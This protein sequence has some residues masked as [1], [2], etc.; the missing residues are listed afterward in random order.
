[1]TGLDNFFVE[2]I[3][4]FTHITPARTSTARLGLI[5]SLNQHPTLFGSSMTLP[6][7]HIF[8]DALT[9]GA[10]RWLW[11]LAAVV[12]LAVALFVHAERQSARRLAR[13]VAARLRARLVPTVSPARRRWRF[14][15]ELLAL[16]ALIVA[17][18]RPQLGFEEQTVKRR[19]LD[20]IVAVDVSKSM[21][22]TDLAPNRL[23]R[24]RLALLDLLDVLPGD[25]VGLV[26]F[27][28]SAFLQAPLT[29]D[30]DAVRA[31]TAE[32][33]TDLIPRGGTDI[34]AA[35]DLALEAF[36]QGESGH[37]A[38]VLL[39]DGEELEEDALKSA[40][41]AAAAGVPIFTV[42]LGTTEGSVIP[43]PSDRRQLG[44]TDFVRDAEGKV[45]RSRLDEKRL[46]EIA[47]LT[48]GS[49]LHLQS[50]ESEM[51]TL[52]Q[53][54]LARLATGDIDA[55]LSR[56]PIERYVWPLGCALF[57]LGASALLGE[58]RHQRTP[59]PAAT[60]MKKNAAL[61][62]VLPQGATAMLC[63][64]GLFLLG[65]AGIISPPLAVAAA[66]AVDAETALELYNQGKYDEAFRAYENLLKADPNSDKLHFNAGAAAFQ[67]KDYDGALDAFSQALAA[68]EE[69][70]L[71][72]STQYNLGNTLFRRGEA[73]KDSA[74]RIKDWKNALDY[75][76]S[77]LKETDREPQ[78]SAALRADA[79]HNRDLVQKLLAEEQ[80]KQQQQQQQ[81]QSSQSPEQKSS[82]GNKGPQDKKPSPK[83]DATN[84]NRNRSKDAR[85][86]ASSGG[87]QPPQP[88]S[89]EGQN[90]NAGDPQQ[91]DPNGR[92]PG[93]RGQRPS[94]RPP[95]GSGGNEQKPEAQGNRGGQ[96]PQ[97]DDHSSQNGGEHSGQD[98]AENSAEKNN[99]RQR[100]DVQAQRAQASKNPNK[101]PQPADGAGA[102]P[103]EGGETADGASAADGRMSAAQ[104][105]AL[106]DALR[107]E[108]DRNATAALQT[109]GGKKKRDDPGYQ[110][111]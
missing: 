103:G 102:Q 64:G 44:G 82:P 91:N 16:A 72:A 5:S 40:R 88:Q 37:R 65:F 78:R 7:F 34:A 70:Q 20:L 108:D 52:A 98:N 67:R 46:R 35:I 62:R 74:A 6:A 14:A 109:R 38:I 111:W 9:F 59:A 84:S 11:A 69:P 2:A 54:Q 15:L 80:K 28:G 41:R 29:I 100:G 33:D 97:P 71:Q 93:E 99:P 101:P 66:T 106:L 39:T 79:E 23:A 47:S 10:P 68:A 107:G 87:Q 51:K 81:Q 32:L 18:A 94:D 95:E 48:G 96:R 110:D 53:T 86:N 83:P 43:L 89:S 49:Y 27:A 105:R 73:Q 77:T 58:R 56:R 50:G 1:M 31:A 21:L 24:A 19:G 4:N 22:A 55:R 26:A 85:D 45:V 13:L 75:F 8:A 30:Y 60:M 42:G 57:A 25:R 90:G 76:N 61:P 3:S 36:G 17:L 104:A 12:P 92:D 63:A